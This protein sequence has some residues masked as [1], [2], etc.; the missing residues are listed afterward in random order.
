M[1][2]RHAR[3]ADAHERRAFIAD[4]SA[5]LYGRATVL[6]TFGGGVR[7]EHNDADEKQRQHHPETDLVVECVV[8]GQVVYGWHNHIGHVDDR[9]HW[10]VDGGRAAQS[11]RF[12]LGT[13]HQC[14]YGA[15]PELYGVDASGKGS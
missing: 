5:T 12:Q 7:D 11:A 13:A 2:A 10:Q 15:R 14:R 3:G 6:Y 8:T 1:L 4:T 9:Q